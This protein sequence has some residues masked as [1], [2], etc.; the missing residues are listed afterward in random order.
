MVCA[1][2]LD[3]SETEEKP[4]LAGICRFHLCHTGVVAS[5]SQSCGTD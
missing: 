1:L 2:Y 4:Y 3:K 5:A